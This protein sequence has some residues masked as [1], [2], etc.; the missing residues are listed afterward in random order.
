MAKMPK[1]ADSARWRVEVLQQLG[2][3]LSLPEK[4]EHEWRVCRPTIAAYRAAVV[5]ITDLDEVDNLPP[6]RLAPDQEGGIQFEWEKGIHN[7]E[8][9]ITP[10]G[11]YEYLET[12]SGKPEN[13][14]DID[15][16]RAREL[17]VGVA[18]F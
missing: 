12:K 14:G 18:R 13:E 15:L 5:L 6:P 16:D 1:S 7:L 8:I 4:P 3:F 9:G 2:Q 10:A 17:V 11:A